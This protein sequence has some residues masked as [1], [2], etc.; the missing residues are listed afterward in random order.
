MKKANVIRDAQIIA[1][2][3]ITKQMS[4]VANKKRARD[5]FLNLFKK[6]SA[7][8]G[9][10]STIKGKS[11]VDQLSVDDQHMYSQFH[12][13]GTPRNPDIPSSI[14]EGPPIIFKHPSPT[15]NPSGQLENNSITQHPF[16]TLGPSSMRDQMSVQ[17]KERSMT[18]I[19]EHPSSQV[20]LQSVNEGRSGSVRL[21]QSIDDN[22]ASPF[23]PPAMYEQLLSPGNRPAAKESV[24]STNS[25]RRTISRKQSQHKGTGTLDTQARATGTLEGAVLKL[26]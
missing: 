26:L 9:N 5:K 23:K 7:K 14:P 10:A 11:K 8:K 18:S 25:R 6:R 22:M 24:L 19:N 13:S 3:N 12:L 4:M 15:E 16:S 21:Q 20:K 1:K 2:T 17:L